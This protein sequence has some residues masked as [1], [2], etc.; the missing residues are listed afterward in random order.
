MWAKIVAAL[1]AKLGDFEL[2][3]VIFEAGARKLDAALVRQIDWLVGVAEERIPDGDARKGWVVEQLDAM[4][5]PLQMA[6]AAAS[7]SAINWAIETAVQKLSAVKA[8][9][10]VDAGDSGRARRPEL[11]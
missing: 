6:V 7:R 4:R 2:F 3:A 5:G 11:D 10:A 1:L 9:P 8:R